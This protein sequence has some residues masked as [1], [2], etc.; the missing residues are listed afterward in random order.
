MTS[1]GGMDVVVSELV[2]QEGGTLTHIGTATHYYAKIGVSAVQVNACCT[3]TRGG[4]LQFT[5]CHGR[6]FRIRVDSMERDH[7]P[8]DE[9]V[10]PDHVGIETG[11]RLKHSSDVFSVTL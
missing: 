4:I 1:V 6:I 2:P 7:V 11:I 8:I 3:I 5:N 10:G 9:A